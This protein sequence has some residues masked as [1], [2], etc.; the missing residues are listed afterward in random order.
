MSTRWRASSPAEPRTLEASGD[1]PISSGQYTAAEARLLIDGLM[2]AL[3]SGFGQS[4][5]PQRDGLLVRGPVGQAR[6]PGRVSSRRCGRSI[7]ARRDWSPRRAVHI[8]RQGHLAAAQFFPCQWRPGGPRWDDYPP[9][10]SRG[11]RRRVHAPRL[12]K[13]RRSCGPRYDDR[14]PRPG[15]VVRTGRAACAF[16]RGR[17]DR[18]RTGADQCGAG[19]HRR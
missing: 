10:G 7:A 4:S 11:P 19:H 1:E 2:A 18:R 16:E 15:G 5:H 6:D 12:R 17:T 3:E 9:W 8:L 13:R 14:L